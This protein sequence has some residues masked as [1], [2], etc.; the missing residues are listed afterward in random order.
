VPTLETPRLVLRRWRESDISPLAGINADLEVMR[1]IGTG[2][3]RS[4]QQTRAGVAAVECETLDPASG[5]PV[6]VYEITRPPLGSR[7]PPG[8]RLAAVRGL[9]TDR[10]GR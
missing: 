10:S 3:A 2:A 4:L 6:R 7:P 1:W 8:C 5:L 9:A